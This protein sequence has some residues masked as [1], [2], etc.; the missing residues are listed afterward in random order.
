MQSW[1]LDLKRI[2]AAEC[3]IKASVVSSLYTL[4]SSL[5]YTHTFISMRAASPALDLFIG[6]LV[7]YKF[8]PAPPLCL[9]KI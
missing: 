7:I 5:E 4:S 9:E 8:S 2:D 1:S 6:L 3:I